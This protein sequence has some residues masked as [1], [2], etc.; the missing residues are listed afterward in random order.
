MPDLSDDMFLVCV[1]HPPDD[2]GRGETRATL[3]FSRSPSVALV[4]AANR[5][6]RTAA[7]TYQDRFGI[8]VVDWRMLVMLTREP[9]ATV[10]HASRVIGID[11]AAVSRAFGRLEKAG[12]AVPNRPQRHAV[13][14]TWRLT[15][16]GHALHAEILPV[17]LGLQKRLLHGFSEAEVV[18]LT[19]MLARLMRNLE[20]VEDGP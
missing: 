13:S 2:E 7:R 15:E 16:T 5:Y 4:F 12:L 19:G 11:K 9:D 10:G 14:R 1:D 6:T 20:S 3:S 17:S 8:G 18:Q